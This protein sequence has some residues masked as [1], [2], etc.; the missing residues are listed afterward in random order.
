MTEQLRLKASIGKITLDMTTSTTSVNLTPLALA[1]IMA[2]AVM[3]AL[4]LKSWP[5]RDQAIHSRLHAHKRHNSK[6]TQTRRHS[7]EMLSSSWSKA[8]NIVYD[9]LVN[10]ALLILFY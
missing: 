3:F 8:Q 1:Q 5:L 2:Q 9:L 7:A 6:Y 10:Y 4:A